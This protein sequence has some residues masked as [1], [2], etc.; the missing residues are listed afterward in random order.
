MTKKAFKELVYEPPD[1]PVDIVSHIWQGIQN[2][3]GELLQ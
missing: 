3:R 2:K 1:Y